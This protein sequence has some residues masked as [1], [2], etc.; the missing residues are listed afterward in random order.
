MAITLLPPDP[1]TIGAA[2]ETDWWQ[3]PAGAV[4]VDFR[5]IAP[6]IGTLQ[7]PDFNAKLS[8]E[9]S[10]DAGATAI[11]IGSTNAG[12]DPGDNP[13]NPDGSPAA[14]PASQVGQS[15]GIV[16]RDCGENFAFVARQSPGC[17][18][19]LR[20]DRDKYVRARLTVLGGGGGGQVALG[21]VAEAL[22]ANNQPVAW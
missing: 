22:D 6:S 1:R 15:P 19:G 5:M 9:S 8:I 4:V 18:P 10:E 17:A 7:D 20:L 12:P 14:T 16:P 13:P 11:S 21:L 2:T 3:V